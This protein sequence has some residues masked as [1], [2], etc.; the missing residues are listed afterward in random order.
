MQ[1]SR[2]SSM[3]SLRDIVFRW[4]LGGVLL[5]FTTFAAITIWTGQDLL[6]V[7]WR[8]RAGPFVRY[9][10][11]NLVK[12]YE[13]S[14]PQGLKALDHQTSL[15]AGIQTFLLSPQGTELRG[16]PVDPTLALLLSKLKPEKYLGEDVLFRLTPEGTFAAI[17]VKTKQG[18]LYRVG[19]IIPGTPITELPMPVGAILLRVGLGLCIAAAACYWLAYHLTHPLTLLREAA[20]KFADGD[21]RARGGM[22]PTLHQVSEIHALATDFDDMASRIE[23]LM[24]GQRRLLLDV[25]H[26]LRT[27]LTRMT[28]TLGIARRSATPE[29]IPSLERIERE[30]EKLNQLVTRVI[31]VNRMETSGEPMV[32]QK[33][34]LAGLVHQVVEDA[35]IEAHAHQKSVQ[36]L[37]HVGCTVNGDPDLLSSAIEN[38]VRNAIRHTATGTGVDVRLCLEGSSVHLSIADHGPG[39]SEEH[40]TRIFDPFFRVQKGR[41]TQSGGIGLGLTIAARAVKLHGGKILPRNL[42]Q[43]GLEMEILLPQAS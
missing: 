7:L 40:I 31:A 21:L 5:L 17:L 10:A 25:S 15:P 38:I 34:D 2:T 9:V 30:A 28:L 16:Q 22:E 35:R 13:D 12:T 32:R 26:E 33:I 18:Q 6:V 27:P 19:L 24:E 29:I 43:G 8:E 1:F 37:D 23:S 36:L 39:V 11:E 14:G 3:R 20:R 4:F 41:E 42:P